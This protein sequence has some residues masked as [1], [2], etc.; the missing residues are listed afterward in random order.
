[1]A[2]VLAGLSGV[3]A[4]GLTFGLS[5]SDRAGRAADE[6]EVPPAE[7]TPEPGSTPDFDEPLWYV[8]YQNAENLAPKFDGERN[9]IEITL[10]S[11]PRQDL[12]CPG[13]F[14]IAPAGQMLELAVTSDIGIPIRS[15]PAGVVPVS[16][17]FVYLCDRSPFH[18]IWSFDVSAET[19]GAGSGGSGL[20]I[21]RLKSTREFY[22][23]ASEERWSD[24]DIGGSNGLSLSPIVTGP[25]APIGGCAVLLRDDARDLLTVVQASAAHEE[26]CVSVAEVLS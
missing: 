2:L 10:N 11:D 3:T 16:E 9:G 4:F 15:L 26:F 24:V 8:P 14:R 19:T 7:A 17:P 22:L 1:M 12:L 6:P 21:Y 23:P 25:G 18:I 5:G 20:D 13:E